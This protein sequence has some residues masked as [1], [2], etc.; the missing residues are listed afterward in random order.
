MTSAGGGG[1]QLEIIPN[2][3]E[4]LPQARRKIKLKQILY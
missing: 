1:V 2:V 3:I 4:T